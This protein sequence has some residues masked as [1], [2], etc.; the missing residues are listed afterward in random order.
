MVNWSAGTPNRAAA[1]ARTPPYGPSMVFGGSALGSSTI[2]PSL[3]GSTT[4]A[5]TGGSSAGDSTTGSLTGGSTT[6]SS[7]GS[8]SGGDSGTVVGTSTTGAGAPLTYP[9]AMVRTSARASGAS[10]TSGKGDVPLRG[11]R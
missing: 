8:S 2:G 4:G 7:T 11:L 5:S 10:T 3:G 1:S 6:G 9:S